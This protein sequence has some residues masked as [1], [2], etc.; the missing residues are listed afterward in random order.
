M[1]WAPTRQS[2][3][4]G[5]RVG[6]ALDGRLSGPRAVGCGLGSHFCPCSSGQQASEPR[7][8]WQH[9]SVL[10]N[11]TL[12]CIRAHTQL[13]PALGPL[14]QPMVWVSCSFRSLLLPGDPRA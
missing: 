9:S 8:P 11:C 1:G 6:L 14:L 4:L 7:V 12:Q 3:C 5:G 13:G 2:L 10:L